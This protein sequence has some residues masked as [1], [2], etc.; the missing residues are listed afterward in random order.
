MGLSSDAPLAAE[1]LIPNV[2]TRRFQ[3]VEFFYRKSKM[4]TQRQNVA[5]D[6][7]L[8]SPCSFREKELRSGN[9]VLVE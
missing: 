4:T 9:T 6:V 1:E 7:L 8:K 5:L 3:T 2:Y